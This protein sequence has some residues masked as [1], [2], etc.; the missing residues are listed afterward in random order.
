MSKT[1]VGETEK[2]IP[3]LQ[4]LPSRYLE[5]GKSI[6]AQSTK[7][8]AITELRSIQAG[9]QFSCLTITNLVMLKM[10]YV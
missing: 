2:N 7:I 4:M 6:K 5:F 9:Q 8:I 10:E 1:S 3:F